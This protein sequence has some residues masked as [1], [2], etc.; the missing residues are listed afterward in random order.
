MGQI[1][2]AAGMKYAIVGPLTIEIEQFVKMTAIIATV[3]GVI[4]VILSMTLVNSDF[5]TQFVFFVGEEKKNPNF[6]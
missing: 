3:T 1:A 2:A 4:F 5:L 6:L